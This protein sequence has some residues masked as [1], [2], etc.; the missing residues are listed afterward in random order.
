MFMV[1][2]EYMRVY[3]TC[4]IYRHIKMRI[5]KFSPARNG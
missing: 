4:H 3:G 5:Y 2:T 1:C